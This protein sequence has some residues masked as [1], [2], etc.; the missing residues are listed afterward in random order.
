MLETWSQVPQK[1]RGQI[2]AP[3]CHPD[4]H[5]KMRPPHAEPTTLPPEA[6]VKD[7]LPSSAETPPGEDT[8]V[9]LANA[10]T[11]T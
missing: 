11:K 2:I 8:M 10:D 4:V 9:L 3:L 5:P 1:L 7:T 6:D